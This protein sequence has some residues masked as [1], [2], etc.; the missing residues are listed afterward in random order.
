M[1][2]SIVCQKRDD[3][4]H[5]TD[6]F[7]QEI[8]RLYG[9]QRTIILDRDTKFLSYFWRSPWRLPGTKLLFST[10]FHPKTKNR[11]WEINSHNLTKGYGEQDFKGLGYQSCSYWVCLRSSCFLWYLSFPFDVC[12]TLILSLPWYYSHSL[13][14]KS[15]F[16]G[17]G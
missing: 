11:R 8:L 6:M 5:I 16:W 4:T 15:E 17:Q 14:I 3:V 12:L 1:A 9:I 2:H 10:I 7:F 13:R